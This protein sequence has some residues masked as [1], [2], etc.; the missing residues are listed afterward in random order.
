MDKL[1]CSGGHSVHSEL[2]KLFSWYKKKGKRSFHNP[3]NNS[4]KK[5]LK[6][7]THTYVCLARTSQL[8]IPDSTERVAMKLAGLGEKRF[9]LFAHATSQ[10]YKMNHIVNFQNY[11][12]VKDLSY[13]ELL[14]WEEK[15]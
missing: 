5:P 1:S 4:K 10:N 14:E 2:S 7:C 15:S 6:T 13:S 9:S 8:Y 11:V 12:M 3:A